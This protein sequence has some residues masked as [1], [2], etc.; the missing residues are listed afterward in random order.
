MFVVCCFKELSKTPPS[1]GTG[2]VLDLG[3]WIGLFTWGELLLISVPSD[4]TPLSNSDEGD[5]LSSAKLVGCCIPVMSSEEEIPSTS[6]VS[7]RGGA[8]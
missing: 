6:G 8:G 4:L 3:E 1:A 7:L 5:T 2:E